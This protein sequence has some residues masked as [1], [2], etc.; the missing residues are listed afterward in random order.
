MTRYGQKWDF[1]A[2]IDFSGTGGLDWSWSYFDRAFVKKNLQ[3]YILP[4]PVPTYGRSCPSI[5]EHQDQK[6]LLPGPG[7]LESQRAQRITLDQPGPVLHDPCYS[8]SSE[9]FKNTSYTCPVP[10]YLCFLGQG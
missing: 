10:A 2:K 6:H 8:C 7:I 4:S 1:G 9:L 5:L 3:I